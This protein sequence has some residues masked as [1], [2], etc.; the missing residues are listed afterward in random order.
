MQR[1]KKGDFAFT[2]STAA[3][4]PNSG[5]LVSI[6]EV[7]GRMPA[8][9]I[10]FGYLVERVDGKPFELDADPAVPGTPASR[11]APLRVFADEG[12]LRPLGRRRPRR[13]RQSPNPFTPQRPLVHWL[14]S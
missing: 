13:G 14:A 11:E 6:V 2:C 3:A 9:G 7:L 10:G 1:F 4:G 8:Y 12:H 5:R